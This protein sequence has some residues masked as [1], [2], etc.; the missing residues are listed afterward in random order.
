MP[1]IALI[2]ALRE[3][4]APIDAAFDALW[5]EARRTHLLD[6][7]L[8]A[9]LAS[10]G[11]ID[12]AMTQRFLDLAAYVRRQ[13][14]D[15]ILFTCSAFGLCIDAVK[16]AHPE[17][18]VLKPNEAMVDEAVAWA[19]AHPGQRMGLVA[20][21]QPTLRSMPQEFPPTLQ[22]LCALAAQAL[23]ALQRGDGAAHDADA[24]AAAASLA[25]QG[26]G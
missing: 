11:A 17:L 1:R 3:S 24:V 25:A 9:D 7:S 22:P 23:P 19:R 15:A 6:D 26:C 2:H 16:A 13:G 12:A 18:P 21:F 5:P 20:S 8:S 4:P 14:A 10:A